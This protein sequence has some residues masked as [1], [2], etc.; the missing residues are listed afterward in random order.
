MIQIGILKPQSRRP[1]KTLN[2]PEWL[3]Q[4]T[5]KGQIYNQDDPAKTTIRQTTEQNRYLG[6]HGTGEISRQIVYDPNQPMRTTIKETTEDSNHM[7]GAH[8][9]QISKQIAYDPFDVALTTHRETTEN[10]E[11]FAPMES[12]QLQNGQATRRHRLT[13]KIHNDSSIVIT[14]M[15]GVRVKPKLKPTII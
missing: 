10:N 7:G 2:I 9:G 4:S 6:G 8:S 15:W 12:S 1:Q 5:Q 14:I 11:Y 3:N 13:P